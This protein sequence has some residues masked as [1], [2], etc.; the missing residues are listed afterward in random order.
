MRG[1][2]E[3]SQVTRAPAT[4]FQ[5]TTVSRKIEIRSGA[6]GLEIIFFIDHGPG[7]SRM[8]V[9]IGDNDLPDLL[10]AVQKVQNEKNESFERRLK[11]LEEK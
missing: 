2:I 6:L 11:Q 10:A 1:F 5:S 9:R 8:V 4:T 3:E 7:E